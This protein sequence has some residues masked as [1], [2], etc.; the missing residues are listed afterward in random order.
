[1]KKNKLIAFVLSASIVAGSFSAFQNEFVFADENDETFEE[2]VEEI[3]P[4]DADDESGDETEVEEVIDEDYGFSR[5]A[6]N[7]T[8]F[9]DSHFR[10]WVSE[11]CDSDHNSY[12]SQSE[13]S[14]VTTI[15]C[16]LCDI[17]I[18]NG[19]MEE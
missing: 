11:N 2:P 18:L 6:I 5:V 7:D 10:D 15:D 16:S 4:D 9:P 1:M 3:I 17:E 19:I 12:L 8:N 13:I 14:E